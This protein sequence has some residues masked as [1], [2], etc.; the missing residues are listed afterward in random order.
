MCDNC[1]GEDL[2]ALSTL[3]GNTFWLCS[4]A[5]PCQPQPEPDFDPEAQTPLTEERKVTYRLTCW[6][7]YYVLVLIILASVGQTFLRSEKK[8]FPDFF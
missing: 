3:C 7:K 6:G 8:D 4:L 2:A 5:A 1:T